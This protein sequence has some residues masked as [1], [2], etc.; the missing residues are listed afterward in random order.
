M[1]SC[2]RS[3]HKVDRKPVF[4]VH[5]KLLV[6][7]EPAPG[8]LVV[9]HPLDNPMLSERPRGSVAADGTFE[10]TTYDGKDGAPPG[11][12]SVTVEWRVPVDRGEGPLPG[13]NQLPQ[14]YASPG[15]S[16]LRATVSEGT[17]ELSPITIRR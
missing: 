15:T 5:G 2:S 12:Y 1:S 9:L 16:D 11:N 3:G 8:A 6:N 17:N 13:P 4:P 10:L 14:Q 7:D